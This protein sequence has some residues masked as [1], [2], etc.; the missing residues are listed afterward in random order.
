MLKRFLNNWTNNLADI[1]KS[2]IAEQVMQV[3]A[4]QLAPLSLYLLDARRDAAE[5]LRTRGSVWQRMVSDPGLTAE[6]ITDIEERLNEINTLIID[7]SEVLTHV[8]QHLENV[9]GVLRC[10]ADGISVTP[11]ARQLRDLNKG[12]DVIMST[13]GASQF[14]LARQ[15]LGTRSLTTFFLF[16]AF[17]S[18]RQSKHKSEALHPLVAIEEPEAHLHP[19]AQRAAFQQIDAIAGQKL[20]S[21]HSPYVCAQAPIHSFVHFSKHGN[22][23]QVKQLSSCHEDSFSAEDI[24]KIEREV[25][26]TRGELLFARCII[27]FE[28]ET[29][30]QALPGLANLYWK[31][32]WHTL[33]IT[34]VGVGG[35]GKY[36][37]FLRTAKLFEIPWL[38][39]SDGEPNAIKAVED[40]LLA[41]KEP[42]I[43]DNSRVIVIPSGQCFEEYICTSASEGVLREMIVE[44]VGERPGMSP[45]GKR[46][47]N[48]KCGN[49]GEFL[50]SSRAEA[51]DSYAPQFRAFQDSIHQKSGALSCFECSSTR[52][53]HHDRLKGSA[54][55]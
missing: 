55:T 37:P 20:V 48:K 52:Q 8:Q 34:F 50:K 47:S 25:M 16:R 43:A 27:L 11:V 10:D 32:H 36:Q 54:R 29:E 19:Q 22:E 53:I 51:Q 42:Q 12:M 41:V 28:G 18:W 24:R 13:L 49:M 4:T 33:G 2:K 31:Q 35:S 39:F 26:N 21:T 3:S 46:R 14:P 9:S 44:Y 17:I 40:A 15:G 5:D 23:T 30:E 45:Q 1:D 38:I 7:K 6:D